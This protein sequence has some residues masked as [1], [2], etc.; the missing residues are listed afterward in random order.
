VRIRSRSKRWEPSSSAKDKKVATG[1]AFE[2]LLEIPLREAIER[3]GEDAV[4]LLLPND[5]VM[6]TSIMRGTLQETLYNF[7]PDAVKSRVTFNK[8]LVGIEPWMGDKDSSG[9][10]M[11]VFADGSRAGPF[12]LV[13]GCDGIKS[14]VKE[15]VDRGRISQSSSEREGAAAG[16]YTGLRIRYAVQ[17]G[18]PITREATLG[19]PDVGVISQYFGDAAYCFTAQFGAGKDRPNARCAF[20]TFLDESSFG[21]FRRRK[22]KE[23]ASLSVLENA[24]WTQDNLR[25]VDRTR[26]AMMRQI[27]QSGAPDIELRSVIES[28]DRFFELGVY[29]HNPFCKWSKEIPGSNGAW[30]VLAGDAAHALPPFLG[31]GGNQA[32][33]DAYC[34]GTKI[35]RYNQQ[36]LRQYERQSQSSPHAETA[37]LQLYLRDYERIRWPATFQIFW[38]SVFLGYL[39]TGGFQ[40]AY[41][42]FRDVFFKTMGII[43]VAHRVLLSAAIPRV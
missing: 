24:D 10:A 29:I 38:K 18:R 32:I 3:G 11:C 21:P 33:Q 27:A 40:G 4:R 28:A 20:V 43:G 23:G 14:A 7:L 34:L 13:V 25:S 35:H 17:D 39:E 36:F 26:K 1:K 16:I 30:C 31:Q 42:K 2:A 12:D 22:A 5:E 19:G 9:G 6:W 41:S 8:M 15:F 37:V